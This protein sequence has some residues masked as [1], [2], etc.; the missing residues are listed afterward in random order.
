MGHNASKDSVVAYPP[1]PH[2]A[3]R[4]SSVASLDRISNNEYHLFAHDQNQIPIQLKIF[5]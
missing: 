1:S 3:L 4:C 2:L 5:S